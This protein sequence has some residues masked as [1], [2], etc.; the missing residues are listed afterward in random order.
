[1]IREIEQD[2]V[3][4]RIDAGPQVISLDCPDDVEWSN[5]GLVPS[6]AA[7]H[8][9]GF[10][11]GSVLAAKAKAFDDGLIAAVELA[12]QAGAGTFAGKSAFL[13]AVS[14]KFADPRVSALI[15]G[16]RQLG[17]G[18]PPPSALAAATQQVVGDFL[19]DER[20]SKP[21]GFY[22]WSAALEKIFQQDR[23]LQT[24]LPD[25][26]AFT[27]A[28]RALQ[29]H[30]AAYETWMSLAE[31]LT[32]PFTR[33]DLRAALR[34][35]DRGASPEF[36]RGVAFS[37]PSESPEGALVKRLFATRPIPEGFNLADALIAEI[38]K[39]S[40]DLSPKPDSGWYDRI[41]WS[42]ETLA[43]PDR[44]PEATKLDLQKNYRD[45]LTELFKGILA[46]ARESHV[47]QLEEPRAGCGP[48]RPKIRP[49]LSAEPL[50]THY[51]RRALGYRF[52]R[53]VLE[54]TFGAA[55][56][57]DMRRLTADGP[58]AIPLPDELASTEEL[59]FG[60]HAASCAEI[61]LPADPQTP[62]QAAA[63][64]AGWVKDLAA[65]PDLKT[66]N[67]MMVPV[68]FDVQRKQVKVWVLLG[69][70]SRPLKASFKTAPKVEIL[71]T[72]E[73]KGWFGIG[74]K[75][76]EAPAIE[77]E[78]ATHSL[79]TP[80]TAEVYVTQRLNRQEFRAH[81]DKYRT[82]E[83]ILANLR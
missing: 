56:L 2:G 10:V 20:L 5:P 74:K 43:A 30:R 82:K 60:A 49:Q 28:A 26:A 75:K 45:T 66:D 23:L 51:L 54:S 79:I 13:A 69:W 12:M 36:R 80:V 25:A 34:D 47:K 33:P 8:P 68:F 58:V 24:E 52:V 11:S 6:V 76:A 31:R 27:D 42:L 39:G 29:P 18:T 41:A 77:F 4:L 44:G 14:A 57:R 21:L 64:F 81:C 63:R 16:A 83:E 37:P 9:W 3:R 59:F 71:A 50:P 22:T 46:L 40:V 55:A 65:D 70:T 17:S 61:G 62:A 7:A 72:A 48:P 78:T 1:M 53:E 38:R 32:N 35:L 67:R 19:R 73:K 15:H